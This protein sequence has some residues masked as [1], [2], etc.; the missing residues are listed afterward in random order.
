MENGACKQKG[1][2]EKHTVSDSFMSL[3]VFRISFRI[4]HCVSDVN[5]EIVLRKVV[6]HYAYITVSKNIVL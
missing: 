3:L 1:G 6:S 5:L 4:L 2:N